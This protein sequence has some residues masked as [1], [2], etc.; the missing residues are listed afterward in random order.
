MIASLFMEMQSFKTT[1]AKGP[2]GGSGITIY[3]ENG[4]PHASVFLKH[5][6]VGLPFGLDIAPAMA[7]SLG[8]LILGGKDAAIGLSPK[9]FVLHGEITI[10]PSGRLLLL[11]QQ[12]EVLPAWQCRIETVSPKI[13]SISNRKVDLRALA[14]SGEHQL[15]I[16]AHGRKS[17]FGR[18]T[19]PRE[20]SFE[21][22][23]WKTYTT[24]ED[25]LLEVLVGEA[26]SDSYRKQTDFFFARPKW[27]SEE[28]ISGRVRNFIRGCTILAKN[29]GESLNVSA[30]EVTEHIKSVLAAVANDRKEGQGNNKNTVT[31]KPEFFV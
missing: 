15:V 29:R 26:S 31:Q 3:K 16:Y 10:D 7:P 20:G 13:E 18:N 4:R 27:V 24:I 11:P 17:P 12:F 30:D 28:R 1:D 5:E 21:I 23:N 6:G 9:D 2:A 22:R 19:I 14:Q 25:F 8:N